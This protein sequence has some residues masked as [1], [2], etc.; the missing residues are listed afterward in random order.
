MSGINLVLFGA[1]CI[2]GPLA[3]IVSKHKDSKHPTD[4][5]LF[6]A[7]FQQI[8][9]L[10]AMVISGIGFVWMGIALLLR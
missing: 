10:R 6:S 2:F 3:M 1:L 5:W 8:F 7:S 9:T 4:E